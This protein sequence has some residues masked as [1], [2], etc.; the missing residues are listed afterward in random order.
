MTANEQER[1]VDEVLVALTRGEIMA[2][3]SVTGYAT[4]TAGDPY[5]RYVGQSDPAVSREQ[6]QA[7]AALEL[8][9]LAVAYP[10]TRINAG[11]G[12]TVRETW[13]RPTPE[14]FFRAR[15]I[16]AGDRA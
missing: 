3:R 9:G 14:G 6:E 7:L 4:L 12:T 2:R 10:R 8:D 5:P 13:Y 11:D 1:L 16:Q 15:A